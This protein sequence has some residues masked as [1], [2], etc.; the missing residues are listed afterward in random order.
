M[1]IPKNSYIRKAEGIGEEYRQV[2]PERGKIGALWN[3]HVQHHDGDDD[4]D[5][6]IR[7]R[8]E[9]L[10][11]QIEFTYKSIDVLGRSSHVWDAT[12]HVS[13]SNL[14]VGSSAF[15]IET[16]PVK[17]NLLRQ[18]LIHQDGF[19]PVGGTFRN[20]VRRSE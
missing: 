10:F 17:V 19:L 4:G 5:H 3:F 20:G 13:L 7:E 9:P 14:D 16:C 1:V 12:G 6:S 11:A 8:F 2:G 18:L 15:S